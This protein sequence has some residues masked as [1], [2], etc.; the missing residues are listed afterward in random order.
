MEVGEKRK[1]GWE[2]IQGQDFSDC[3]GQFRAGITGRVSLYSISASLQPQ[4]RWFQQTYTGM[5]HELCF[6]WHCRSTVRRGNGANNMWNPF[7]VPVAFHGLTGFKTAECCF[8]PCGRNS[9][10]LAASTRY[11]RGAA[12]VE[13]E[14][15]NNQTEGMSR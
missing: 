13:K 8:M 7:G 1:R 4:C 11:Q 12:S 5:L 15:K 10:R 6:Q 3:F 9:S 2:S 14:R